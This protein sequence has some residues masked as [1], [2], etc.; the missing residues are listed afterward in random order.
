MRS[1]H[2]SFKRITGSKHAPACEYAITC[3][4]RNSHE[5]TTAANHTGCYKDIIP[6]LARTH[7]RTAHQLACAVHS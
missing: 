3:K 4:Y 5:R 6:N 1:G 2:Y 7:A